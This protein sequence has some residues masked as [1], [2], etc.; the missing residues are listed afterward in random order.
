[1]KT[2]LKFSCED[3]L[4]IAKLMRFLKKMISSS[5]QELLPGNNT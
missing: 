5:L 2:K 3:Q 4:E 1:M